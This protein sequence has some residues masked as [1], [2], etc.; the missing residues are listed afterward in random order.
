MNNGLFFD[1]KKLFETDFDHHK[2]EDFQKSEM[3]L[4]EDKDLDFHYKIYSV[5][6]GDKIIILKEERIRI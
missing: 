5:I 1:P 3:V 2:F 4:T 6:K